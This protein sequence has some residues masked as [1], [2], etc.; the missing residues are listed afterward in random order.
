MKIKV[1]G[2]SKMKKNYGAL[3]IQVEFNN[4]IYSLFQMEIQDCYA[5]DFNGVS[6]FPFI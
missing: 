1:Y 2:R 4:P 6:F 3:E 5:I